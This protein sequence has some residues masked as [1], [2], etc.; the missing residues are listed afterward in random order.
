MKAAVVI[1]TNVAVAANGHAGDD[2][3]LACI[4]ALAESR[5]SNMILLDDQ[6]LILGEYRQRLSHSGQPGLGDAFFKWLWDNQANPRY[7]KQVMITPTNREATT[8]R[9]FPDDPELTAFD[10]SDRKFVATAVASRLRPTIINAT[11]T[12]WLDIQEPLKRYGIAVR[13]VCPDLM[14]IK[15]SRRHR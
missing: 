4:N 11:D 12:D 8:F 2:C 9:E 10:P 6:G 1:D 5:T 7:C 14:K 15:K 13:F 3:E